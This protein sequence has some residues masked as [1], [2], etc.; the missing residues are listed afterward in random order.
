M[1]IYHFCL[2]VFYKFVFL[3]NI[4]NRVASRTNNGTADV[5]HIFPIAFKPTIILQL[6]FA[7][8]RDVQE[9]LRE[10]SK[11]Q[12]FWY[13]HHLTNL[14]KEAS[15]SKLA[16]RDG[17]HL[18]GPTRRK[19]PGSVGSQRLVDIH[20]AAEETSPD[21][22]VAPIKPTT[23]LCPHAILRPST[24]RCPLLLLPSRTASPPAF[25]IF[26]R[27]SPPGCYVDPPTPPPS[28]CGTFSHAVIPPGFQSSHWRMSCPLQNPAF[29]KSTFFTFTRSAQE[30]LHWSEHGIIKNKNSKNKQI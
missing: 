7:C 27:S 10:L 3:L 23:G 22:H 18:P 28:R 21:A 6:S 12:L 30:K 15:S 2:L 1:V 16:E 19:G 25:S 17:A 5:R 14:E 4:C 26:F 9:R 24:P 11:W 13:G 8:W 29:S 20:G